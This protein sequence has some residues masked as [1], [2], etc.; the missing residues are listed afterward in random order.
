MHYCKMLL[1]PFSD[2]LK[3]WVFKPRNLLVKFASFFFPLGNVTK[4]SGHA[5]KLFERYI[6][7]N[8]R[9]IPLVSILILRGHMFRRQRQ[10]PFQRKI[11]KRRD[12]LEQ[13]LLIMAIN[14]GNQAKADSCHLIHELIYDH[15]LICI[16]HIN[17]KQIMHSLLHF[18]VR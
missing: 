4:G 7:I 11:M 8:K 17:R 15:F 14:I 9:E 2:P 13:R 3:F 10:F 6:T 18:F 5:I 16:F 12:S 1:E